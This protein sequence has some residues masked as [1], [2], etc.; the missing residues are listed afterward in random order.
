MAWI[1]SHTVLIRHRKLTELARELRLKP[2]YVMGHLHALWHTALEQQEDGDLSSWSDSYIAQASAYESDAPRWVSLLQKH[3][4]LNGKL[5]HDWLDYAGRYLKSKYRVS[6][7]EK[8]N[9]MF[10]IHQ[11]SLKTVLSPSKDGPPNLTLPTK[12]TYPPNLPSDKNGE[13]PGV[14]SQIVG[15]GDK[16]AARKEALLERR[17]PFG[18]F[19]GVQVLNLPVD[20]CK[21]LLTEFEGKDNIKGDLREALE[22]R[23]RSVRI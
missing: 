18:E 14:L 6:D 17:M 11:V 12:P 3:G 22:H 9:K 19:K 15:N 7:P 16:E 4:W 5:I 23:I 13:R 8:L 10:A 20:R 2:V 21:W 1:E